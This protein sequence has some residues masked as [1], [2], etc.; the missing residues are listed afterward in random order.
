MQYSKKV[1][2]LPI[3]KLF[4]RLLWFWLG[5]SYSLPLFFP[6]N[7]YWVSAASVLSSISLGTLFVITWLYR[8]LRINSSFAKWVFLYVAWVAFT[9]VLSPYVWENWLST[10]G[11]FIA[12]IF[13]LIAIMIG[14][15]FLNTDYAIIVAGRAYV[16]GVAFT[17]INL[18][19]LGLKESSRFGN[20]ELL[21]PNSLGFLYS[22]V[23]CFLLSFRLFRFKI[24]KN[25]VLLVF[26]I[27]LVLTFSKTSVIAMLV[28]VIAGSVFQQGWH[29]A[30]YILSLLIIGVIVYIFLADYL[31]SQIQ[32]YTSNPYLVS[33]LTGRTILWD[34]VLEMVGERPWLGYGYATFREVFKLYS[35]ALGFVV[36]AT[37][38]H[39]ALLD[40]M[41]TGGYIGLTIFVVILIKALI[42]VLKTSAK[43]QG[44]PKALFMVLITTFILVR[45]LTEGSLNLGRDFLF[46]V[47][48][49]LL[50]ERC[51]SLERELKINRITKF[52]MK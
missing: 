41:F 25:L 33:T 21:H 22:S 44:E 18:V 12:T 34:W 43:F 51:L 40:V 27:L 17:T 8:P 42:V 46:L 10:A 36:P 16:L 14:L 32:V 49:V 20:D 19:L 15:R 3:V 48:T 28:A 29:K 31:Q 45:S 13:L 37:Q 39:N 47:L 30:K 50:G 6:T 11:Y 23:L 5:A 38:A 35:L 4:W 9:S 52:L 1:I 26:A 24:L 2:S 7:L